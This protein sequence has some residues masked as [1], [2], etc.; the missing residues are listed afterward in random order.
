M[1][2]IR[3]YKYPKTNNRNWPIGG[4][5]E[6]SS[7]YMFRSWC[8]GEQIGMLGR[9]KAAGPFVEAVQRADFRI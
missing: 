7:I 3:F 5:I 8:F 9:N 2:P 6:V 1:E 4:G